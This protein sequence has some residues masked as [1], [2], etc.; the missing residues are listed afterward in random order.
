MWHR[1]VRKVQNTK[2]HSPFELEKPNFR[3]K[4]RMLQAYAVDGGHSGVCS[5]VGA[6]VLKG[7]GGTWS[8]TPT[9]S[10]GPGPAGGRLCYLKWV[11]PARAT[12]ARSLETQRGG[13]SFPWRPPL[14]MSGRDFLRHYHLLRSSE[15]TPA[16]LQASYLLREHASLTDAF[17]RTAGPHFLPPITPVHNLK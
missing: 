13:R 15:V 2:G 1:F 17:L 5:L 16:C 11:T 7:C 8:W 12:A 4:K 3:T 6:Q 10:K 14:G 9:V